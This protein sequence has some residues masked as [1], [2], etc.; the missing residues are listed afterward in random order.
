MSELNDNQKELCNSLEGFIV[1]DAGPG[2]GKT[3]SIVQRYVNI[4]GKGIEPMEVLMLTFTR[5]AAE[6]ME[7]RISTRMSELI[8]EPGGDPDGYLKNALENLKV[9]T[10]DSFCLDVVLN[11]PEE[12]RDF[13]DPEDRNL[14]LSRSA[15]LSEN[16]TLNRQ[17]F[18]DFYAR[19]ITEHGSEYVYNGIDYA[20]LF[21]EKQMDLYGLIQKLMSR[22]IIPRKKGWMGL[23][24]DTLIGRREDVFNAMKGR[25]SK[26]VSKLNEK[27]K[28][29]DYAIPDSLMDVK[30]IPDEILEAIA[31]EDREGLLRL[32]HDVYFGYITYCIK[33]N[34]LTFGLCE[35]FALITL[36]YSPTARRMYSVD[37]LTIDE[38]Q[39]TN[40]LQM[41]ICLLILKQSNMCVVG[42]WKQGIFGFR[43]VSVENI[44]HFDERVSRFMDDLKQIRVKGKNLEFPF[45]F[46]KSKPIEFTINYRSSALIIEKGFDALDIAGSGEDVPKYDGKKVELTSFRNDD[47]RG[48]T[49]LNYFKGKTK[50]DEVEKVVCMITEY[51]SGD[52]EIAERDKD[53]NLVVRKA[54]FG[55]IA[56]L[57]RSSAYC[58]MIFNECQRRHVP[59]YLQGDIEI[60][61][62]EQG[63]LALAWLRYL[64]NQGDRRA[65][66]TIL[67]HLGYPLSEIEAITEHKELVPS[68]ITE[69]LAKLKK[70]KRRVTDLITAIFDFYGM[71]DEIVHTIINV[72]SSA[73]RNSLMTVSDMIRLI[74]DDIE[75]RT[76]YNVEP[77]I[78]RK[79]VKIQTIHK[80][81]GLEYPIV[82]ISGI[83]Q[84]SF[85]S[86]KQGDSIL[87]FNDE[88]GV[89]CMNS[90]LRNTDEE[91][92][93]TVVKSW[94]GV[95]LKAGYPVDYSEERRLLF[96]AITRAKQYITF[97]S[98][99]QDN[100]TS[101]FYEH[102]A[103]D[104]DCIPIEPE[105]KEFDESMLDSLTDKPEIQEY[106][107]KRMSLSAHDL[108]S[109]LD[110]P[111]SED[112]KEG[113]GTE[114][115]D[116]VHKEAYRYLKWHRYDKS[117][118]EMGYITGMIDGLLSEK[119]KLS[120]EIRCVLPVDDV[121]VKGTI[122]LLAEF[123]DRFEIHDYKTDPDQSYEERYI[124]QMSIYYHAVASMGKKVE[125]Y[126]DYVHLGKRVP[127]EPKSLDY[128]RERIAEYK[129]QLE[130]T[131]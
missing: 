1:V 49:E 15:S 126:I 47:F 53:N 52:Y 23:D 44:T 31:W 102:Y 110:E 64:N 122:D 26:L 76:K 86:F 104:S 129:R 90:Y 40:E 118:E 78:D 105:F 28:E 75:A 30:S 2:T 14:M 5:N 74:E 69:Q 112:K 63:K 94:E 3:H 65:L 70:K 121:S 4:I 9:S 25:Q 54:D 117:I 19:F 38:F 50:A 89:R 27:K 35:L 29:D 71:N 13:F 80:S 92:H 12:V 98:Y 33:E 42:D 103:K 59:V 97:T 57:C 115:G 22:G 82:I 48:R 113:K 34:R 18:A 24:K 11:S 79:A 107:R 91:G 83:I 36:I 109:T 45:T 108:M 8:A 10:I 81:K 21:G 95:L 67:D 16:E 101:K 128:I 41:K 55:D 32:I 130:K 68:N 131:D 43:Y 116:M 111:S 61:S 88:M 125:C 93:E 127:V 39:D 60:M 58:T 56:V 85:P 100:G 73:H 77:L 6:E 119:A 72:L 114:Y 62:S 120:G 20:A 46:V 124:L 99:E 17:Y 37:Y 123:D 96:V 87:R 51:V 106:E 66:V 84:G 7:T